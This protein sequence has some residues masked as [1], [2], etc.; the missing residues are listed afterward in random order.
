MGKDR[1]VSVTTS[2]SNWREWHLQRYT[3]WCK[4]RTLWAIKVAVLATAVVVMFAVGL[5]API[6]MGGHP[7]WLGVSVTAVLWIGALF[8]ALFLSV[9]ADTRHDIRKELIGHYAALISDD[10]W[11]HPDWGTGK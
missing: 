8:F 11:I 6:I 4:C 1:Q 2:A 5:A 7:A 9:M 10:D 3:Y